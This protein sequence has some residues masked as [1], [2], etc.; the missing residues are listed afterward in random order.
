MY[1]RE[2]NCIYTRGI[3]EGSVGLEIIFQYALQMNTKY[4]GGFLGD[5]YWKIRPK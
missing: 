2:N 1:R 3:R 4:N 5:G